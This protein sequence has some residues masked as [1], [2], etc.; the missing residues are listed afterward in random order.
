MPFALS[1]LALSPTGDMVASTEPVGWQHSWPPKANS[2]Q[3]LL[4]LLRPRFD[5]SQALAE[6]LDRLNE[7]LLLHARKLLPYD[8]LTGIDPLDVEDPF[9]TTGVFEGF[10]EECLQFEALGYSAF[11]GWGRCLEP[12][13]NERDMLYTHDEHPITKGDLVAFAAVGLPMIL[14]KVFLGETDKNIFFWCNNPSIVYVFAKSDILHVARVSLVRR[15]GDSEPIDPRAFR[16]R[17]LDAPEF[18]ASGASKIYQ[19]ASRAPLLGPKA[20]SMQ[21]ARIAARQAIVDELGR[22]PSSCGTEG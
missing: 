2:Q 16:R 22:L 21:E 7:S 4:R 9:D 14:C 5:A 17:I 18:A 13:I 3:E 12:V 19:L 10:S 11:G 15:P 8:E 1:Q 6:G 20:G